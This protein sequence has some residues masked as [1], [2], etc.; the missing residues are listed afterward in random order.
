MRP[1]SLSH[2]VGQTS[3][4]GPGSLLGSLL[5]NITEEGFSAERIGQPEQVFSHEITS[6]LGSMI[7]WGPPGSG[8]TTLAR[9]IARR[10]EA[11]FKELSA[12]RCGITGGWLQVM[13]IFTDTWL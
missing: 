2:Y 10:V 6:S 1:T 11:D 13:T 12:T 7:F 8:K 9:L 5:D 4:V 3:I